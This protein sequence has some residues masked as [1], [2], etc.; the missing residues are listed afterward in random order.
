M[1]RMTGTVTWFSPGKGYGFITKAKG[2]PDIFVH[3]S[4]IEMDGYK[5]LNQGDEVTFDTEEGQNGKPQACNVVVTKRAE[6]TV[7]AR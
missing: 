1:E 5:S 7:A 6:A 3:Y 2:G 4:A